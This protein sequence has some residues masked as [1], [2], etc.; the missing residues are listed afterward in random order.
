MDKKA[1]STLKKL[2]TQPTPSGWEQNGQKIIADYMMPYA[3]GLRYDLHDNLI[4]L[5]NPGA[6]VRIMI[7]GH[8]DEIGLIVQ[9]IDEKGYLYVSPIGGVNTQLLQAERLLIRG[10]GDKTVNGIVGAPP[11]HLMTA[12]SRDKAVEHISNLWVDIGAKDRAE[13]LE[14]VEIGA[15]VTIDAGWREL[16]GDLISARAFDDRIGAF[17][18]AEVLRR[19][20][21][22]KMDVELHVVSSVR[23]EIGLLGAHVAAYDIAPH[24]GIAVDVGFAT[25]TPAPEKKFI[26]DTALGGGPIIGC[27][28]ILH[29]GLRR[30]MH[31]T[32]DSLDIPTQVQARG[33]GNGNN[34]F[35]IYMSRSGAAAGLVSIP[36][37]YM[38]SPV[39]TLSLNDVEQIITLLT[40]T[41][42]RLPGELHLS[43]RGKILKETKWKRT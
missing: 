15:P 8:C 26:G 42:K 30:M 36:L 33:R 37:R 17:I 39:E 21:G 7:D 43:E 18:N 6:A 29:H 22:C 27:S 1:L 4:A 19:L 11:P 10:C 40:E 12:K 20:S 9:Y 38:H 31:Q 2:I 16:H 34:A 35:A 14:L 24:A 28:P 32:A 23:E 13:A 3:D 5:R 25:D 41:V